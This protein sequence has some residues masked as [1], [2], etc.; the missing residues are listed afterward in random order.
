MTLSNPIRRPGV[1]AVGKAAVGYALAGHN[2][3]MPVIARTS[4]TPYRWTIEAAPLAKI[5]NREKTLPKGFIRR[6][7]YGITAAAR[8]HLAPLI[9]GEA[10]P[11]TKGGLPVYVPLKIV[12]VGKKLAAR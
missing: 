9:A 10:P 11:P 8:R 4:D 7:G 5:A 12:A 3:V 1:Y 6:D 2:A